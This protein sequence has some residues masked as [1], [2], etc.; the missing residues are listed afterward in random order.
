MKKIYLTIP[1]NCT[2]KKN[3]RE[4]HY[5]KTKSGKLVKFMAASKKYRTWETRAR[6]AARQQLADCNISEPISTQI[7][8]TVIAHMKGNTLDL[9]AVHTA[10][11]DALEGVAWVNDK[12]IK[13]FSPDSHVYGKSKAPYTEIIIERLEES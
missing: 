1:G 11:M 7:K 9:D 12:Q 2:S 4:P 13:Q 8:L 6:Q 5:G 10:V 3:S